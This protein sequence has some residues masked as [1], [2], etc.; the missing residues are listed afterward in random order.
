MPHPATRPR[1]VDPHGSHRAVRDQRD[2][3]LYGRGGGGHR[4]HVPT[5]PD[6]LSTISGATRERG[7]GAGRGADMTVVVPVDVAEGWVDEGTD[8]FLR[9]LDGLADAD[10]DAATALPG[11]TRRHVLA[12]VASNAE[13]IGRLVSWARSGRETPMY[14]SPRQR[15][16]DIESG[17]RR[18]AADLRAWVRASADTLAADF[19]ALP[20]PAWRAM[21]VTAQGRTVAAFELPWMRAREVAVHAVDLGAGIRFADL[22]DGFCRALVD[23][24]ADR[25]ST[26]GDG[27]LVTV[28]ATD[29]DATWHVH[30]HGPPQR[31]ASTVAELG[32]WLSGRLTQAGLPRLPP[33]L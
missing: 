21:V 13:A 18:E 17:A 3:G 19:A 12:H 20:E 31:V 1:I 29:V 9:E 10:L 27:P 23:D 33:W 16:A 15:T 5:I 28:E 11:W 26:R 7:P 25:R 4:G 30:G 14:A 22:P 6:T 24:I 32:A 8:L 2:G